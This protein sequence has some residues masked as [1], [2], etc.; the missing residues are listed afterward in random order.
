MEHPCIS[1]EGMCSFHNHM[2]RFSVLIVL[3]FNSFLASAQQGVFGT[4]ATPMALNGDY[5]SLGWNPAHITLSP[6]LRNEWKSAI[7][8]LEFSGR[9]ASTVLERSE[10]WDDLLNRPHSTSALTDLEWSDWMEQLSEEEVSLHTDFTSAATAKKWRSWGVAYASSQHFQ[11]EAYLDAEPVQLLVAGGASEWFELLIT[12]SG[13]TLAN[14]GT[15]QLSDLIDVIGGIDQN[16][17]AILS[18]LLQDTRL[19]F[20]WH[21]SHSV[22]LSKEWRVRDIILHT[23]VSGSLLLGNGYFQLTNVN[24]QMDAF[25]AFSKAFEISSL[26]GIS[27]DPTNLDS[28]RKL[29]PV[30]QGWGA[31]VGMAL[32]WEDRLWASASV[33]NLGWIEWEGEKYNFNLNPGDVWLNP[34]SNSGSLVSLMLDAMDPTTWFSSSENETRRISNGATFHIGGGLKLS[35]KLIIAADASFDNPDII[36]NKGARM[37]LSG[38]IQPLPWIRVDGGMSKWGDERVRMPAGIVF[39]TGTRGF[40]CGIQ[41]SDI[42]G[43]WKPSQPEI[44]LKTCV[45]RWL[46]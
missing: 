34:V 15:I 29:G 35:D 36:G 33:S 31:N 40:E 25:G 20:S 32:E 30:G 19:G 6:L 9:L 23:G 41:A 28:W 46:W 5:R 38:V 2:L 13:D 21:S 42:Q 7:G 10:L 22:G 26:A 24:G 4:G 44:G 45:I 37:G 43:I 16:G 14:D 11:A 27:D 8:G 17:D 3:V 1:G 39:M 12:A 18:E